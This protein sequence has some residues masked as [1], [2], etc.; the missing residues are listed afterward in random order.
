V[1]ARAYQDASG[2]ARDV[3]AND[4]TPAKPQPSGDPPRS[5]WWL[6]R[7][8]DR[9]QVIVNPP[10]TQRTMLARYPGCTVTMTP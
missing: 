9:W 6:H 3:A 10:Q 5:N 1:T 2:T 4:E 8:P 7:G